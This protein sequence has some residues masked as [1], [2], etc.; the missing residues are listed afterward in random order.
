MAEP[1]VEAQQE[2][3]PVQAPLYP[4]PYDYPAYVPPAPRPRVQVKAD[5]LPAVSVFSLIALVG[6][7]LAW[8]WAQL[9]PSQLKAVGQRGVL[10]PLTA[11]SYHR[12]DS[13]AI[14]VGLGFAAGLVV[15]VGIWFLRERR[16]PVIMAGAVLGS[17]AAAYLGTLMV[18]M[19]TGWIYD[20]PSATK[21]GDVV[22]I[23]P[24]L[25]SAWVILAQPLA[26]ALAYGVLAAWN[27]MDDLGRRLG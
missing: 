2:D 23:A 20:T 7:P 22:T 10:I 6:I 13:I 15:G 17:L 16:G 5:I 14:F 11:E 26:T 8:L 3:A 19:F 18:G 4:P 27:G 9:A 12:F 24:T 25:E 1:P 21:L